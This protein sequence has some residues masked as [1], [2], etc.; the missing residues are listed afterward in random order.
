MDNFWRP[1]RTTAKII[2]RTKNE[3]RMKEYWRRIKKMPLTALLQE[4]ERVRHNVNPYA[5]IW[6]GEG[7][8]IPAKK[9]YGNDKPIEEK[10]IKI[11][12]KCIECQHCTKNTRPTGRY[13]WICTH[14]E[15]EGNVIC[16]SKKTGEMI[17]KTSPKWCPREE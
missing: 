1:P 14:P 17:V 16:L 10:K 6:D 3:H 8:T 5:P 11:L 7:Y 9:I 2:K 15:A 4:W 12:R 13:E